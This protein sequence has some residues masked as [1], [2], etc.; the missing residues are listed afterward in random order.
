MI[1]IVPPRAQHVPQLH[2]LYL[3]AVAA[4][5]HCRFA[6]DEARFG[7]ELLGRAAPVPLLS[8][9]RDQRVFVAEE[10]GAARGF[11]ALAWYTD[12]DGGEHQAITALFF[13]DEAAG[14]ALI[15]ACEG[16]A[17]P[18]RLLAFPDTHGKSPVAEYNCGWNGLSDRVPHVA[19][20]LVRAG[21]S[22]YQR[23][24]H[25][26]LDLRAFPPQ[27]LPVPAGVELSEEPDDRGR[28]WIRAIVGGRKV[29][30][31]IFS[32]LSQLS[33]DA[34]AAR[35]GYI[36]GLG[37]VEGFRR[38]GLARVLMARAL[39]RLVGQGCDACWLTTTADNWPA[40]PLYLSLGFVVV[41]CSASFRKG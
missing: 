39:E 29:A 18:G 28:V 2:Q 26:A 17:G 16:A 6:P 33:P 20:A 9:P 32:T 19:R 11:A 3:D 27:A 35:T 34:D 22:P 23:E 25:M 5:P 21:Y 10:G 31:C 40:Q 30:D 38:R 1:D 8:A 12:W 36:W 14:R 7:D 41:D 4:A 24:L 15:D 13:A 37:V